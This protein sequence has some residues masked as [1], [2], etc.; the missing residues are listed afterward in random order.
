MKIRS[1]F[2]QSSFNSKIKTWRLRGLTRK[3]MQGREDA[4]RSSG[5]IKS[6]FPADSADLH[7]EEIIKPWRLNK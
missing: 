7:R 2:V 4:K 3:I 1:F 5:I 6:N